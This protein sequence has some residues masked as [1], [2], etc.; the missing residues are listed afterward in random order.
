MPNKSRGLGK[1]SPVTV[2]HSQAERQQE[3]NYLDLSLLPTND[4]LLG[5]PIGQT[6]RDA[7]KARDSFD[8]VHVVPCREGQPGREGWS[9]SGVGWGWQNGNYPAHPMA[10][11]AS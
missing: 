3:S 7:K 10:A 9:A 5:H 2:G 8:K 11:K 4:V 1:N 6:E